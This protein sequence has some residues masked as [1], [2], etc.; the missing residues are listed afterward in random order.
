MND[1]GTR[2]TFTMNWLGILVGWNLLIWFMVA[3]IGLLTRYRPPYF[4]PVEFRNTPQILWIV[5]SLRLVWLAQWVLVCI[6][7][8]L[9]RTLLLFRLDRSGPVLRV[10]N[11]S[12][13][14]TIY[15]FSCCLLR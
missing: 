12:V 14:Y 11:P 8:E 4:A 15:T 2:H 9:L 13:P 3:E 1:I 7:F 6:P 5:D 10:I